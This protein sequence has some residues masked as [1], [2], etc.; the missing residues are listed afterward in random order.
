MTIRKYFKSTLLILSLIVP[1]LL[2]FT[3]STWGGIYTRNLI[4]MI[5][6]LAIFAGIFLSWL[7]QKI[8]KFIANIYLGK[9]TF[10]LFLCL[11][12]FVSF[13]NIYIHTQYYLKPW[14]M[15]IIRKWFY[16]HIPVN[17]LI[18]INEWDQQILFPGDTLKNKVKFIPLEPNKL[19]SLA[20]LQREK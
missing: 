1:M 3:F 14:S 16:D 13:Q 5:P 4:S 19:Y 10:L 17:S 7:Y 18:A 12:L 9:L 8:S 20:E 11:L 15:T 6:F 2:Y